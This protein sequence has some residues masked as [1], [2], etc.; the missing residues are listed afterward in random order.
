MSSWQPNFSQPTVLFGG[1]FDPP[2]L[3]HLQIAKLCQ[4]ALP[5]A[6][7]VFLPYYQSTDKDKSPLPI[8][9]REKILRLSLE[10]LE[11]IQKNTFFLW[12]YEIRQKKVTYTI[13]TLK[14]AHSLGATKDTLFLLLGSEQYTAFTS[15]KEGT[16]I[17]NL[18][19]MVVAPRN[20]YAAV[21]KTGH[22]DII[23][24]MEPFDLSSSHIRNMLKK[25]T[26][27]KRS[28]TSSV[29]KYLKILLQKKQNPYA[30]S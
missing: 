13:D 9:L 20:P 22:S 6:Q 30:K 7:I 28:L 19:R 16:R 12:D 17:Q 21:E 8:E 1:A 11:A 23:L 25:S 14:K 3:G 5:D 10:E 4:E 2:H 27:P 26:I 24:N 15:W 18:C 29:E